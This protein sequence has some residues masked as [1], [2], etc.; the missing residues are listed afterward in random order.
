MC[1]TE[2]SWK[3]AQETQRQIHDTMTLF[4]VF[5]YKQTCV[6][7]LSKK[8]AVKEQAEGRG[9]V[10]WAWCQEIQKGNGVLIREHIQKS[11][12]RFGH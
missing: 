7:R 8:E 3:T 12:C 4:D 5:R 9:M 10:N 6:D 1:I 2:F 11:N